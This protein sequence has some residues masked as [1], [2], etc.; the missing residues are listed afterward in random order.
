[1]VP[2][3]ALRKASVFSGLTDEELGRVAELGEWEAF[4]AGAQ[5]FREGSSATKLYI[6]DKGKVAIQMELGLELGQGKTVT[7]STLYDGDVVAW[8]ALV[9]PHELTASAR[10]CYDTRF[11]AFPAQ[12]LCQL[13]EA[14]PALGL[15]LLRRVAQVATERLRDT[16]L[17]LV[18]AIYAYV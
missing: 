6:V 8:S 10:C 4:E 1:M 7:V 12:A 16:H 9:P 18:E 2:K 11:I 15:N 14:D 3:E 17:Q 5:L 13:C